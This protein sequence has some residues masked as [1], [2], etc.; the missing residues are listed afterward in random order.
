LKNKI[1]IVDGSNLLFQMFFGMPSRI[2]NEQGIGIWG[3]LGFVGA[4]L[5]IIRQTNPTHVAVLFD[6]ECT[7]ERKSIDNDYKANRVDYNEAA[8]EENP[9]SQMPFVYQ[10]LD[11][12]GLAYKETVDCEADDWIAGY[13][14]RYGAQDELIISSFDSDFF[15]LV[16]E[17]V[18]ILRYRGDE[19]ILCT[20]EY[21]QNK[22]GITPEQY[23][24]FKSL[25]GDKADNIPGAEKVGLKTAARLLQEFGTLEEILQHTE[26]IKKRTIRESIAKNQER[27]RRNLRLIK[28][29]G[30]CDLPFT[31]EEMWY[32]DNKITTTEV[33]RGIGLKK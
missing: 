5:K 6:G 19:S 24:E 27:L 28:L 22:Y 4:L 20:P 7:N 2:Y 29:D 26:Q 32:T 30:S 8:D 9:F 13:A 10:A 3:V 14:K 31:L 21:I 17:S 33:L 11:Y 16:S 1:L 23:A 15:Q 18:S 25:T 12:L